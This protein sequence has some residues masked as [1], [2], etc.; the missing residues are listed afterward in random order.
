MAL[1]LRN[2]LFVPILAADRCCRVAPLGLSVQ[3]ASA[4]P[5]VFI[6]AGIIADDG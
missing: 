2:I 1:G 6:D 4:H 5:H 3:P